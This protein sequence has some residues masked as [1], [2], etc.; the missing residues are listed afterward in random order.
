MYDSLQLTHTVTEAEKSHNL[1][2]SSWI[3]RK[4][5]GINF[6]LSVRSADSV[7]SSPK[8]VEDLCLTPKSQRKRQKKKKMRERKQTNKQALLMPNLWE[9]SAEITTNNAIGPG[10]S[11][12]AQRLRTCLATDGILL[13]SKHQA[14]KINRNLLL[15]FGSPLL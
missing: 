9:T 6:S 10:D 13:S 5:N 3:T 8:V 12:F 1:L 15:N 2:S 4:T 14:E 7:N 11:L